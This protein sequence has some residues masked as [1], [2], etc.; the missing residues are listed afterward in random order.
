MAIGCL[1]GSEGPSPV[2]LLPGRYAR[3][4]ARA[5]NTT[6][7]YRRLCSRWLARRVGPPRAVRTYRSPAARSGL[8]G[9]S[10][11]DRVR[12]L[13]HVVRRLVAA[14]IVGCMFVACGGGATISTTTTTAEAVAPTPLA[15]GL[16]SPIHGVPVP[17]VAARNDKL[18][19]ATTDAY[20]IPTGTTPEQV[21]AFYD[22]EMP[23]GQ[24]F[25]GLVWCGS[26]LTPGQPSRRSWRKRADEFLTVFVTDEKT[27]RPPQGAGI[28]IIYDNDESYGVC[29]DS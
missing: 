13:G 24:A 8:D 18:T 9:D 21:E 17:S 6:T 11:G 25:D 19:N 4:A 7:T 14:A 28:L 15:A 1:P 16:P 22:A 12:H 3:A 29:E 2:R 27:S 20:L 5:R 10:D 26:D 23:T